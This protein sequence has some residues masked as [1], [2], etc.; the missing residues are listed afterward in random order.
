MNKA[1]QDRAAALLQAQQKADELFKEVEARGIIRPNVLESQINQDIYDLAERMFGISTYWHKRIVRA[2][3]NTLAPYDE[4]P[5]DLTLSDDDIVFLDLGPV[6]EEWEADFGR[7]FVLGSDP[8]KLKLRD[9]IGK[10]FADGKA[11][12][13]NHPDITAAEFYRYAQ[14]LAAQYG[15]EYGGPIAG[16]LLGQFPHERIPGDKVTLYVHPDNPRRMRDLDALGQERHWILEI[17]FVDRVRK[18]GGFYEELI[19]VG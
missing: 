1:E 19:T 17:H 14:E 4:N 2:G 16:H 5:P 6:F 11:Y 15:W 8:H 3:T 12:F 18:I 10:A 7:T 9:D 13:N